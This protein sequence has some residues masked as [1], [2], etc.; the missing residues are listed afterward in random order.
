MAPAG[1]T[2]VQFTPMKTSLGRKPMTF[3]EFIARVYDDCGERKAS[4]LVRFA[5][6][7]HLVE[8]RRPHRLVLA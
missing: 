5:L 1:W 8:F 2:E 4:G 7:A 6:K 3:G